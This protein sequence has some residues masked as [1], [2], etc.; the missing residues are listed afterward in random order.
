LGLTA[1][2]PLRQGILRGKYKDGIPEG[3]RFANTKV[4]FVAGYWKRTGKE[5][6]EAQIETVKQA[7]ARCGAFGREAEHAGAGVGA[8]EPQ[9]ELGDYGR[10]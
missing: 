5:V 7:G 6:W 3:S 8:G 9:C 10:E 2:S 4:E 1:F